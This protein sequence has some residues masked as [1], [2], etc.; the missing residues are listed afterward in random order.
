MT[1]DEAEKILDSVPD[2]VEQ[3][4][5]KRQI[6]T[7]DCRDVLLDFAPIADLDRY[8]AGLVGLVRHLLKQTPDKAKENA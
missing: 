3:L 7:D 1:R 5:A 2:L 4:A 6:S 8:E